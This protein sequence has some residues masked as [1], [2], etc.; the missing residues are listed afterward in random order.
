MEAI[1]NKPNGD[2]VSFEDELFFGDVPVKL[3]KKARVAGTVE[4]R[5]DL[6]CVRPIVGVLIESFCSHAVVLGNPVV[7]RASE[8]ES[9]RAPKARV[10]EH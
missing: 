6:L 1:E 9:I 10:I 7:R 8:C 3:R 5:E 4:G 2:W